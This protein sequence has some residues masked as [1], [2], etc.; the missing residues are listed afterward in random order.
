MK[1]RVLFV[2]ASDWYFWCH[3]MGIAKC[4]RDAGFEVYVTTPP[5]KYVPLIE[6]EGL[7]HV[8]TPFVS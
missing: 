8:A 7:K 4:V 5:G 6:A 1:Q 2:V 3:W